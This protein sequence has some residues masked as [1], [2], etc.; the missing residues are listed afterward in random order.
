M[1]HIPFCGRHGML[2][3]V[4]VDDPYCLRMHDQQLELDDSVDY[5]EYHAKYACDANYTCTCTPGINGLVWSKVME[6]LPEGAEDTWNMYL[7]P[8]SDEYAEDEQAENDWLT[9]QEAR[10][11]AQIMDGPYVSIESG[12]SY[13][14]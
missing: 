3:S 13:R 14:D 11:R 8:T 7:P 10:K 5:K 9:R 6:T 1:A 4:K 2:V 12:Q